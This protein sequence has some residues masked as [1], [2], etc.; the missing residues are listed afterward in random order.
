MLIQV[1]VQLQFLWNMH[2]NMY[3]DEEESQ[4]DRESYAIVMQRLTLPSLISFA[5]KSAL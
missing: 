2:A 5:W 1:I 4:K 3:L